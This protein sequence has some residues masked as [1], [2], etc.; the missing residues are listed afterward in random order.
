MK[1]CT[2]LIAPGDRCAAYLAVHPPFLV[3]ILM[4]IWGNYAKVNYASYPIVIF[5][6]M[7]DRR[8]FLDIIYG[9]FMGYILRATLAVELYSLCRSSTELPL[10]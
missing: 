9:E 8:Q 2:H 3:S 5:L 4:G 10:A 1:T 6:E 7:C